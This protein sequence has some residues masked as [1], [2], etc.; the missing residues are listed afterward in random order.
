MGGRSSKAGAAT[1]AAF[2]CQ[3][4]ALFTLYP[5]Q[6]PSRTLKIHTRDDH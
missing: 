1:E 2:N 3:S 5:D 4:I 6:L